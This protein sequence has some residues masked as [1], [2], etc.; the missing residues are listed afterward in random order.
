[1][2]DFEFDIAICTM[3]REAQMVQMVKT[4]RQILPFALS[5]N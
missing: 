2:A 3:L 1:M 4:A 5:A